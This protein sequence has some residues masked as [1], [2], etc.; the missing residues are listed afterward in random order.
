MMIAGERYSRTDMPEHKKTS[1]YSSHINERAVDRTIRTI[2]QFS[3]IDAGDSVLISISG[4]PDSVFLTH[5]F[6]ILRDELGLDLYGYSLDHSTRKGQSG[7]DLAF[8]SDL[9]SRSGIR[10]FSE[11]VDAAKWCIDNRLSFQAGAREIRRDRLQDI[12]KKYSIDK[13]AL[14]HNLDD[15]IE[16]F[17]MRL[18]RGSGARGLS[19][20]RPVNGK[21]IRPLINT[22]RK[23][24]EDYLEKM[25]I[26]YR[27]DRSNLENKYFRNRIRN[28]LIPFIKDN[29]FK[30]F[31]ASIR[32]SIEIFGDE[33]TFLRKYSTDL[34]EKIASFHGSTDRDNIIYLKIP[35][36]P[37]VSNPLAIRRRVINYA[38]EKILGN[39][40]NI[41][42]RNIEDILKLTNMKTGESKWLSPIR[43]V[44]VFRINS[45][46]HIVN[47][48]FIHQLPG[49]IRSYI[50]ERV[51]YNAAVKTRNGIKSGTEPAEIIIEIGG[52]TQLSGFSMTIRSQLLD[53]VGD[54]RSSPAS[55]AFFDYG[56]ILSPIRVRSWKEGD[57]FYPLGTGGSK[58]LQDFFTDSKV[59]INKRNNIPVFYD[60]KK[61]IWIGNMRIDD[62]VRITAKTSKILCLELFEK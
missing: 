35:I 42:F 16:T 52:E 40:E 24:I 2:K 62:R 30:N 23:E 56:K 25:S 17:L 44:V 26:P 54:Y 12:S 31:T 36:A 1:A 21:V 46:I 45:F 6:C 13:I 32:R 48:D 61:I 43:T 39:L 9:F 27:I 8:V 41:S 47:V 29:F 7:R 37:L 58:K 59:P 15:N 57:R 3:M 49:D 5:V 10:L 20:I 28:K 14:G 50:L 38:L 55:K 34:L 51:N 11:K 4:G 53:F 22:S 18:I 60:R 33:D 19:G